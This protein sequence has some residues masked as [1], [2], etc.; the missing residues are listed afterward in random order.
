MAHKTYAEGFLTR[1]RGATTGE[2]VSE[3]SSD[4]QGPEGRIVRWVLGAELA[5]R[6]HR[7]VASAFSAIPQEADAGRRVSTS[8]PAWPA[9][10]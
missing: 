5:M 9:T 4:G 3:A 2:I 1:D 6:S 8:V 7:K 10:A